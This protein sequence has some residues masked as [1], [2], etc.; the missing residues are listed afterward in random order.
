MCVCV[1]VRFWCAKCSGEQRRTRFKYFQVLHGNYD[2]EG[3]INSYCQ[4]EYPDLLFIRDDILRQ[5]ALLTLVEVVEQDRQSCIY[6]G[7]IY[8]KETSNTFCDLLHSRPQTKPF[9]IL[10]L[11]SQRESPQSD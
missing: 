4:K 5:A 8:S 10:L 3:P 9:H 6:R 11:K 2:P 1:C 7:D